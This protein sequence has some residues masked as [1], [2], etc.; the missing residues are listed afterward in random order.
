MFPRRKIQRSFDTYIPWNNQDRQV[1]PEATRSM[2]NLCQ[3]RLWKARDRE[4]NYY[5]PSPKTEEY[6]HSVIIAS[7]DIAPIVQERLSWHHSR[8]SFDDISVNYSTFTFI[9]TNSKTIARFVFVNSR[10]LRSLEKVSDLI[11]RRKSR[12]GDSSSVM[13]M[14]SSK[15]IDDVG[16]QRDH[17]LLYCELTKYLRN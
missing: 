11:F 14:D 2:Q 7:T 13:K 3:D 6:H 9:T 17:S 15:L 5:L 10:R 8:R 1:N 4:R 16:I 12:E